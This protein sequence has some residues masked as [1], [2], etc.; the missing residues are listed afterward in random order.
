M[1]GTP[2]QAEQTDVDLVASL[3]TA[4]KLGA[5]ALNSPPAGTLNAF[6]PSITTETS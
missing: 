3:S 2:V 6:V 4:E 5:L 1:D